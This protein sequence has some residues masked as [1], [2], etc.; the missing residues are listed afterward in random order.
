MAAQDESLAPDMRNELDRLISFQE[1]SNPFISSRTLAANGFYL[2]RHPD[3]VRCVFCGVELMNWHES[4]I[5]QIEHFNWSP[6]CPFLRNLTAENVPLPPELEIVM[7]I[8]AQRGQDVCGSRI[9]E[10]PRLPNVELTPDPVPQFRR[11]VSL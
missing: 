2:L 5:V 6:M 8:V 10:R 1:W 7:P 9:Q 11:Y 3:V 4:D